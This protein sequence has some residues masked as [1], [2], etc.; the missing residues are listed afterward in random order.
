MREGGA[1]SWRA[2]SATAASSPAAPRRVSGP[3]RGLLHPTRAGAALLRA[4]LS[5]VLFTWVIVKCL[6][7]TANELTRAL[8]QFVADPLRLGRRRMKW[9]LFKIGFSIWDRQLFTLAASADLY[10]GVPAVYVNY[11]EYD[12]FAHAF[13]PHHTL[14]LRA[15]RRVDHSIGELARILRRLPESAYD[16]YV[17]SDHGQAATRPFDRVS[18]GASIEA[19]VLSTMAQPR[20]IAHG[21]LDRG[22]RA[23]GVTVGARRPSPLAHRGCAAAFPDL[24]RARLPRLHG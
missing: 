10:R 18:G 15:L 21:G 16:L 7:L 3:W 20:A 2:A 1:A 4:P 6:V 5:G 24:P 9:L 8:L 14:A 17:L 19:A 11:L 22:R 12:V 23:A 13:G